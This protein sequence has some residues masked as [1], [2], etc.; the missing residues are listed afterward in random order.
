M[1]ACFTARPTAA[2]AAVELLIVLA[3]D[4]GAIK[5]MAAF[6]ETLARDLALALA[7][8]RS[9]LRVLRVSAG[10]LIVLLEILPP[11]PGAPAGASARPP[12]QSAAL[13]RAR[14]GSG[15]KMV[16]AGVRVVSVAEA[17][18]ASKLVPG[19]SSTTTILGCF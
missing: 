8:P 14:M 13:L 16:L 11:A 18:S 6:K 17:T 5:D 12:A 7:L 9:Q 10:S 19:P 1:G 4:L 2:A 15:S 3:A